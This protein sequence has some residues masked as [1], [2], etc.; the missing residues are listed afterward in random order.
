MDNE[1]D[2]QKDTDEKRSRPPTR[3]PSLLIPLILIGLLVVMI[4]YPWKGQSSSISYGYFE[5][6]LEGKNA[7]GSKIEDADGNKLNC[8]IE[9]VVFTPGGAEGVFK[10]IPDAEIQYDGATKIKPDPDTKLKKQFIVDLPND[11]PSRA[12]IIQI[13]KDSEVESITFDENRSDPF[14]WYYFFLIMFSLGLL[15]FMIMSFRRSQSQMMGG[16][17]FLSNF[18]RSPAKKYE[19]AEQPITFKDVAGLE[20]VKADLGEIVEFLKDPTKFQKLGGRVPKGALL[21]GPPGTGKTLLARAVAGEAGVPY[22]SVN[23]SEFILSLI[24]I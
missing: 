24:H 19:A 12:K 22:F 10:V 21:I 5:K 16:G 15:L 7:N 23:G 4:M 2:K 11:P 17:G 13:V 1:R 3:N 8:A 9:R 14:M 20:G 18:S 6:L